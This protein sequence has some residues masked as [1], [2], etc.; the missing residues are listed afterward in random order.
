M[1]RV[2]K[3]PMFIASNGISFFVF[4][5]QRAVFNGPGDGNGMIRILRR[6]K[7]GDKDDERLDRVTGAGWS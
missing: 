3:F 4:V 5:V 2:S 7:A 6:R 1:N